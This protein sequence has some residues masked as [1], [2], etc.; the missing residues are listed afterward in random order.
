MSAMTQV[1][2]A[3]MMLA[4]ALVFG[5]AT[6]CQVIAPKLRVPALIL[7]LPVGFLFGLAAPALRMTDIL[8]P[9]FPV[10]VDLIVAII[11]FQG[12]ME[13]GNIALQGTDRTVVKRLIWLGGSI[14]LVVGTL[15]AHFV[16]GLA[17]PL[18]ALL[19]SILIVSGPTVVT[20]I[21]D[22]A[23]LKPRLRGILLWE[24]TTLDPLGAILAVVVF[25]IVQAT[26]TKSGVEAIG[27]FFASFLVAVVVATLGVTLAVLG[28][29]LVRD[30]HVL[31][32]QVLI[33][34]VIVATGIANFIAQDSGLLTALL[35]GVATPRLAKRF[36]SSIDPVKPFFN[37]IA[38]I[39][40]GVLFISIAAIV[41]SPT[42][43]EIAVPA[44]VV[45]LILIIV[46]RPLVA[47][48]CTRGASL[49]WRERTFVG[50]MDPRGI[51]AAATAASV[52]A[53]LVAAHVPD[54]GRLLP[55][56]FII[57][58]VTVF[59]YGLTAD[60]LARALGLRDSEVEG[61]Q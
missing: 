6:A 3:N 11:L 52:G 54:A 15:A 34:S 40:I 38:S 7:L 30:N 37:T 51:V 16:L 13:L 29:R 5:L 41:P 1:S 8:G 59:V 58:T 18:A 49:T 55:A 42:V 2:P 39:G 56:A 48:V 21:L 12:G 20:P 27:T 9:V 4:A 32:T 50:W 25:Q 60:P 24:G 47:L 14:T 31:G 33:G 23:Q 46:G 26:S 44:V 36:N 61:L 10:A 53:S 28:V 45:A 17:W 19:G 22:L 43:V 35:M 57:I